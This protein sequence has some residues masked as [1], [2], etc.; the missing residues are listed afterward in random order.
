MKPTTRYVRHKARAPSVKTQVEPT[1][2]HTKEVGLSRSHVRLLLLLCV[3][4]PIVRRQHRVGQRGVNAPIS[5]SAGCSASK[6]SQCRVCARGMR[7]SILR[8]TQA[9]ARRSVN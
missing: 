6:L 5:Y 3:K 7:V 2:D 9:V 8:A 4:S 1:C